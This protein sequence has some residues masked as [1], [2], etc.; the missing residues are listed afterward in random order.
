MNANFSHKVK[1]LYHSY[2]LL[3]N[4]SVRKSMQS[5]VHN[6]TIKLQGSEQHNTCSWHEEP[7]TNPAFLHGHFSDSMQG[8]SHAQLCNIKATSVE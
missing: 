5:F 7:Q 3:A 2:L 8:P 6:S 1:L 4:Q